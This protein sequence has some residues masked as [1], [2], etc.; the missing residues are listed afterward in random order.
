MKRAMHFPRFFMIFNAALREKNLESAN[1]VSPGFFF[2][3][4]FFFFSNGVD[5]RTENAAQLRVL[6]ALPPFYPATQRIMQ[7]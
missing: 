7:E 2:F 4:S 6:N 1:I 5:K 3:L